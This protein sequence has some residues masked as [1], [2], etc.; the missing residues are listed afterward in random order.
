MINYPL[1]GNNLCKYSTQMLQGLLQSNHPEY[2]PE[3]SYP[4]QQPAVHCIMD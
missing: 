3:G 4:L 2:N 1:A